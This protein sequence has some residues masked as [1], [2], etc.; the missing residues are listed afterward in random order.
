[1]DGNENVSEYRQGTVAPMKTHLSMVGMLVGTVFFA[2]SLTPSLLPRTFALQGILSGLS[3]AAGYGVGAAC[4]ALWRHLQ[5]PEPAG[6]TVRLVRNLALV[7]VI[8][9]LLASLWQAASWQNTIRALMGYGR[10][11]GNSADPNPAGRRAGFLCSARSGTHLSLAFYYTFS[12]ARTSCTA[13]D[14]PISGG[15]GLSA[16]ILDGD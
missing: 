14:F 3:F 8:S 9:M 10:I 2:F 1:M 6:P 12:Q 11:S 16:V 5:L 13:P 15:S 4:L 7:I